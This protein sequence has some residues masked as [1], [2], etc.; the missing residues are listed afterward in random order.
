MTITTGP[1][2]DHTP[3]GRTKVRLEDYD[4]VVNVSDT[5]GKLF[6]KP[7]VPYYWFPINESGQWGHAP[8]LGLSRVYQEYNKPDGKMYIHCHA[9][10]CRAPIMAWALMTA[11]GWSKEKIV[12]NLGERA[13]HVEQAFNDRVTRGSIPPD[14]LRLMSRCR[15]YPDLPLSLLL[16]MFD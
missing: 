11:E 3:I 8:F 12:A 1:E 2:A 13:T 7:P 4:V 6:D 5:A 9:G 15:A 16:R 14:A 10:A